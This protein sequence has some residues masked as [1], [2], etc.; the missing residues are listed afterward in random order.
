MKLR[1][2]ISKELGGLE[3]IARIDTTV[4]VLDAFSMLGEFQ[5]DELVSDRQHVEKKDERTVSDLMADQIEFDD[6]ILLNKTDMVGLGSRFF[7]TCCL[8]YLLYQ[9]VGSR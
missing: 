3:K 2:R 6:V 5:T 8:C 7:L 1:R 4:T 9:C